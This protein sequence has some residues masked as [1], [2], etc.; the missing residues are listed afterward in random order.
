[1]ERFQEFQILLLFQRFTIQGHFY[2]QS[3]IAG[4]KVSIYRLQ[5]IQQTAQSWDM[6]LL[7]LAMKKQVF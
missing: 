4:I 3:H 6:P 1:M 5:E 7:L 2:L